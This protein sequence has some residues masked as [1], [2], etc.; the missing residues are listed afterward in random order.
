MSVVSAGEAVK[1]RAATDIVGVDFSTLLA[2]GETLT[3]TPSVSVQPAGLSI[4]NEQI[5]AV[6]FTEKDGL[7]GIPAGKG[8]TM[9]LSGGRRGKEYLVTIV[10]TNSNGVELPAVDLTVSVL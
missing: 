9:T 10:A 3:G 8:V 4:D 6:E 7:S 5:N 2:E 1:H